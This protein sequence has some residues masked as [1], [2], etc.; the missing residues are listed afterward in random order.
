MD[1]YLSPSRIYD[2]I[3]ANV[4]TVFR[5]TVSSFHPHDPH[6]PAKR[7][8]PVPA[9]RGPGR[10][11]KRPRPVDVDDGFVQTWYASVGQ[12]SKKPLTSPNAAPGRTGNPL[13]LDS[14]WKE[15]AHGQSCYSDR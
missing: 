7:P 9:K 13:P 10:P 2:S 11:R 5:C 14:K 4:A 6:A 8:A 15:E 3:D 12:R 1:C